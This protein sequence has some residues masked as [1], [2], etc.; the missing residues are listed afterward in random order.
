M[1]D[2]TTTLTGLSVWHADTHDA[3]NYV[4]RDEFDALAAEVLDAKTALTALT[5]RVAALEAGTPPVEPPVEPPSGD[6]DPLARPFADNSVWNTPLGT[7]SPHANSDRWMSNVE[8]VS[9]DPDQ[10]TYPLYFEQ[11]DWGEWRIEC[12]GAAKSYADG[13]VSG[14]ASKKFLVALPNDFAIPS[15]SD[16]QIIVIAPDGTEFDL[17]QVRDVDRT[18]H[19]A[20]A[21]NGSQYYRA[22][23]GPGTT[24]PVVYASRGAGVPYSAGMIR[25]HEI[26]AGRIPHALAWLCNTTSPE[27]VYPATKS[28]GRT[29]GGI[30]EGSR[31]YIPASTDIDAMLDR[32]GKPLIREA[33]IIARALQEYGA[34]LIDSTGNTG[35]IIAESSITAGWGANKP[36]ANWVRFRSEDLRIAAG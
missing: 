34:F 35:K 19:T 20:T 15:G 29:Q 12:T 21:T 3:D 25:K 11:D 28:D 8:I 30:P 23:H 16:A 31:L 4:Q 26:D 1:S 14:V 9:I 27:H 5:A 22:M 32:N 10:Y 36:T 24:Y 2:P 6:W 17:W 13:M 18:N 33:K 7:V